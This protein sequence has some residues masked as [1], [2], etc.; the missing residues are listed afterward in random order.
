MLGLDQK[1]LRPVTPSGDET[2]RRSDRVGR[3]SRKRKHI[4][5]K[6]GSDDRGANDEEAGKEVEMRKKDDRDDTVSD[7]EDVTYESASDGEESEWESKKD[8]LDREQLAWTCA[9]S[10]L[11]IIG[12]THDNF[13]D[14]YI[15]DRRCASGN[16][17]IRNA[18][19]LPFLA[20]LSDLERH[21]GVEVRCRLLLPVF[22]DCPS[23]KARACAS[24]AHTAVRI[25]VPRRA[26]PPSVLFLVSKM[27]L[28]QCSRRKCLNP[29]VLVFKATM[30][31]FR[32]TELTQTMAS[33]HDVLY[34]SKDRTIALV[35]VGDYHK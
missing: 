23:C 28:Q 10:D 12:F 3:F 32:Y 25:P 15:F 8:L 7:M 34:P 14:C 30:G 11:G 1:T 24:S 35:R 9:L 2:P 18:S 16:L 31:D 4:G 27:I 26:F 17:D 5:L 13:S 33:A 19:Y 20:F 6:K 22:T 21:F 29:F